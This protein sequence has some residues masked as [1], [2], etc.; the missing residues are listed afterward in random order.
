MTHCF[1][2]ASLIICSDPWCSLHLLVIDNHDWK[3]LV[4]KTGEM[5][6]YLFGIDSKEA[7][8]KLGCEQTVDNFAAVSD[9]VFKS[10]P[11]RC[12]SRL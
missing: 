11:L 3:A 12:L 4:V 5:L 6:R 8:S 10:C 1:V 2:R 7:S 9:E